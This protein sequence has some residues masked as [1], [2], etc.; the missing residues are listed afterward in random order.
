MT[1]SMRLS[2][3]LAFVLCFSYGV[4]PAAS[5]DVTWLQFGIGNP[6][7][8]GTCG[9]CVEN[10]PC[11]VNATGT[12]ITG[13]KDCEIYLT[14]SASAGISYAVLFYV[15]AGVT[16]TNFIIPRDLSPRIS[17]EVHSSLP[18][19]L[20]SPTPGTALSGGIYSY[21]SDPIAGGWPS[22][23]SP[24]ITL[25]NLSLSDLTLRISGE[26]LDNGPPTDVLPP[27]S[28]LAQ[29]ISFRSA[30]SDIPIFDIDATLYSY[31]DSPVTVVLTGVD[32]IDISGALALVRSN[33]PTATSVTIDNANGTFGANSVISVP[34]AKTTPGNYGV[35]LTMTDTKLKMTTNQ[36]I[37]EYGVQ[38]FLLEFD[39]GTDLGFSTF[40]ASVFDATASPSVLPSWTL[41]NTW[42]YLYGLDISNASVI[43]CQACKLV[44]CRY[45]P[46]TDGTV[47]VFQIDDFG[48][49]SNIILSHQGFDPHV[50]TDAGYAW[51]VTN[52]NFVFSY[53]VANYNSSIPPVLTIEGYAD[54]PVGTSF[55]F[56]GSNSVTSSIGPNCSVV[57]SGT[58]FFA[59]NS[60][61]VSAC[62][63]T[64]P[65]GIYGTPT[66]VI[67]AKTPSSTD[68]PWNFP[69]LTLG[70]HMPYNAAIALTNFGELTF[71][72]TSAIKT[73][74]ASPAIA[75]LGSTNHLL[76]ADQLATRFVVNWDVESLGAS[77]PT[78]EQ[79]SLVALEFAGSS[80]ALAQIGSS[81]ATASSPIDYSFTGSLIAS[82]TTS[83]IL[84]VQIPSPTPTYTPIASG[85]C[86]KVIPNGFTCVNGIVVSNGSIIISP[87][88]NTTSL[89]ISSANVV[90][91]G[92]LTIANGSQIIFT[93][94]THSLQVQG[95]IELANGTE[96]VVDLSQTKAADLP[97]GSHII[98]TQ[99]GNCSTSLQTAVLSLNKP[100]D[101]CK[102]V[103]AS[104][105]NQS[106]TNTLTV[107][108]VTDSSPCNTKWIILGAV[109]GGVILI[110]VVVTIIVYKV[111]QSNKHKSA[112]RRLN[113]TA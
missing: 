32:F 96:V 82:G 2:I 76:T 101:T 5:A 6:I 34:F 57:V 102:K 93:D 72:F 47:N 35:K 58:A 56:E 19:F 60:D 63:L 53:L 73:S 68:Y 105:T 80:S 94:P 86:P 64:F 14:A 98:L 77:P 13:T 4:L 66:S 106:N 92:N 44:N 109:L 40:G 110:G 108:F 27:V 31:T 99:S 61:F 46:P 30:S 21:W 75:N 78:G 97:E 45:H 41:N 37:A 24:I 70:T 59:S 42:S 8:N 103:S 48:T 26:E 62:S 74:V 65:T 9:A 55:L 71:L 91:Q 104:K 50:P 49:T 23:S 39:R 95:C 52:V 20:G 1:P 107:L 90:I 28:I 29:N 51:R 33:S 10:A 112:H 18:V 87:T 113:G 83:A 100:K 85:T 88:S 54:L 84:A 67:S 81:F 11:A 17:M 15:G 43:G 89:T 79:I 12:T 3:A 36:L 111:I 22:P 25:Y 16:S 7:W 69:S 38:G